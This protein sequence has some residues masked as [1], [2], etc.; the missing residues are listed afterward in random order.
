MVSEKPLFGCLPR[1]YSAIPVTRAKNICLRSRKVPT[2]LTRCETTA[3][4]MFDCHGETNGSTT[5]PPWSTMNCR[6]PCDSHRDLRIVEVAEVRK[7]GIAHRR[8]VTVDTAWRR[9]SLNVIGGLT[10]AS[11]IQ[12]HRGQR[13]QGIPWAVDPRPEYLA[14][15]LTVGGR[16]P[17]PY[18]ASEAKVAPIVT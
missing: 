5:V 18:V 10:V 17:I 9:T 12:S 16:S 6:H 2:N 1:N 8:A 7:S 3:S 4:R 15:G 14:E 13:R 11:P